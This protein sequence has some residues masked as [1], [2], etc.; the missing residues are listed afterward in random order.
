MDIAKLRKRLKEKSE[1]NDISIPGESG[2]DNG[3]QPLPEHSETRDGTPEAGIVETDDIIELLVFGLYNEE[4]AFMVSELEEIIRPQQITSI[5]RTK[6]YLIGVTSLRGKIIPVIDLKKM[7]LLTG[8]EES[9]KRKIIVLKGNKGPLGVLVDRIAG[10]VRLPVSGL[11]EAPAHLKESQL[12]YIN[13]VAVFNSRF[14]SI[15]N[16][17]EIMN[18]M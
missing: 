1:K 14:I 3:A 6:E 7:L 12:R 9:A 2:V 15:I 13:Q 8:K 10:V 18:I 4:Y 5:P 16:S 11:T 17:E